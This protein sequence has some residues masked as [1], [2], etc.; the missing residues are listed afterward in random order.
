MPPRPF[1][2]FVKLTAGPYSPGG[3]PDAFAFT[4]R[5]IVVPRV[6]VVPNLELAVSQD[7]VLI[8]YLTAPVVEL[9]RY[10]KSGGKNGPPRG[11]E[12][13]MLHDQ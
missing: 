7:G 9:T 3:S 12:K 4:V 6:S 2:T 10:S 1:D 13:A 11:P 5:V 8:E